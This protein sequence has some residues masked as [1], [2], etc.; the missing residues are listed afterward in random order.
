VRDFVETAEASPNCLGPLK[1][2]PWEGRWHLNAFGSSAEH[3][4]LPHAA[5]W[6]P[7]VHRFLKVSLPPYRGANA[8]LA[9]GA[10][11]SDGDEQWRRPVLS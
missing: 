9:G 1:V 6:M 11:T 2:S 7:L 5:V 4:L 8:V 3:V 10:G